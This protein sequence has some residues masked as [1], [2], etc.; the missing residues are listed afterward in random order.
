LRRALG[1]SHPRVAGVD[2]GAFARGDR[3]APIAAVFVS[4]PEHLE[5]AGVGRVR[6]DGTDGT[7]RVLA[8]LRSLGP[9]GGIRAVLLDG[10][11][12]GGFNVLD[13]D[14]IHLATGVPVVAVT[15]RPPDFV[16]IARALRKWFPR[17][18]AR[19]LA[20]LR[21][22]R[23][24]RVPTGGEPILAAAAGCT[25]A[26]ASWLVRR[27]TVRGYWPEPLRLAHL[28]ASAGGSPPRPRAASEGASRRRAV[29][30]G[31][32]PGGGKAPTARGSSRDG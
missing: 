22:H 20:L 32:G 14:A 8:L 18:A 31:A 26:D 15:R 2:D 30:D 24:F 7:R 17:S 23:L 19:R 13:L 10:A 11:V 5:A 16:R 6:V 4:A 25:A 1:K 28:V 9:L 3:F 12:V 29:R 21:R 27:V